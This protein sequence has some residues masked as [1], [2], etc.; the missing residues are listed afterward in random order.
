MA[1]GGKKK[2]G[3]DPKLRVVVGGKGQAQAIVSGAPRAAAAQKAAAA[4]TATAP[5]SARGSRPR[6]RE[7]LQ[8]SVA[9]AQ[10]EV[11][12]APTLGL[13]KKPFDRRIL[14]GAL[15]IAALGLMWWFSRG[16]SPAQSPRVASTGSTPVVLAESTSV[17]VIPP[18][19]SPVL[20]AVSNLVVPSA[21]AP[22]V[23]ASASA[24]ASSAPAP[25]ASITA[26]PPVPSTPPPAATAA[27]APPVPPTAAAPVAPKP[28]APKPAAP[29]P[30]QETPY[31]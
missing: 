16:P 10:L 21:E 5:T 7:P 8:E 22:V 2:R 17:N 26:A 31:E 12:A 25:S 30:P 20:P 9:E 29:K 24:S 28:T 11:E 6:V 14:Y 19:P 13:P 15:V 1:K 23:P 18:P 3:L 27:P 4:P